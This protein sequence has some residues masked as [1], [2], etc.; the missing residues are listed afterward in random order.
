[1]RLGEIGGILDDVAQAVQQFGR[2]PDL[3]RRAVALPAAVT[4]T[5]I[6]RSSPRWASAMSSRNAPSGRR[7][8]APSMRF[9]RI[10]E[11][12][13]DGAAAFG[14]LAQQAHIFDLGG[15]FRQR[16]LQLARHH[17]DGAERRAQLMRRR[18]GQRAQRRQAMLA[19][20]RQLGGGQARRHARGFRCDA[21]GIDR[22][23]ADADH[24]RRP[25]AGLVKLRQ[26]QRFACRPGQRLVHHARSR[27]TEAKAMPARI[28]V[29][30]RLSVAAAITTGATNIRA[31]GL[32]MPPV[33]YSS[34]ASCSTSKAR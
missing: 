28:S 17:R 18:G 3:R 21:P 13:D 14:L 24:Q 4:V 12:G 31:K 20:Q 19:R 11:A 2:A 30:P 1:M 5:R 26:Q 15:I 27:D 9:F 25:D 29:L 16:A 32:A 22:G 34:A 7:A 10:G 23:E 6:S 8:V 33:R